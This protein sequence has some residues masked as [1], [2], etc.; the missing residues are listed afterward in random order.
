MKIL[1]ILG[2]IY[3]SVNFSFEVDSIISH[4]Q[5]NDVTVLVCDGS[6]KKCCGNTFGNKLL[7][8]ECRRRTASVLSMISNIKIIKQKEVVQHK[9]VH[10]CYNYNSLQELNKIVYRDFE[11][12][13]GV[14]SYYISLTS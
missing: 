7:C 3:G 14:S 10:K 11:I 6:V 4:S 5:S 13:Y 9:S 12:G 8:F 1:Y 2:P